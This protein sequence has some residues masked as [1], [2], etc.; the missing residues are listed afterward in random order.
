M[1]NVVAA[2]CL[3]GQLRGA[4]TSMREHAKPVGMI[5]S[6]NH[7]TMELQQHFL[8]GHFVICENLHILYPCQ[9]TGRGFFFFQ[10]MPIFAVSR[11]QIFGI[12]F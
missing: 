5:P 6:Q 10:T 3:T 1:V 12:S 8:F 11:A 7:K 9:F 4:Q 2:I